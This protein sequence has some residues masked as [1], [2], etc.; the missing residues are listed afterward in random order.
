MCFGTAIKASV[1]VGSAI[2]FTAG[3]SAC[4]IRDF[5]VTDITAIRQSAQTELAFVLTAS[6]ME[7]NKTKTAGGIDV[8]DLFSLDFNQAQAKAQQIA[9]AIN[10]D[11]KASYT[12]SYFSQTVDPM[13]IGAYEKC[14]DHNTP[15]MYIWLSDRRGDYYIF[16]AFWVGDDTTQ[17]TGKWDTPPTVTSPAQ[18]LSSPDQWHKGVEDTVVVQNDGK[19]GFFLMAKV[20]GKNWAVC[21]C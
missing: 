20:G 8:F 13:A 6:Q 4:D 17:Q 21:Y 15:G 1:V 5:L 7:F 10:F 12:S 19:S 3:A 2:L 16:T 14:L 11:S 9:Q 18:I